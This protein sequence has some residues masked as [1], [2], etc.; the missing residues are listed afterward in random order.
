MSYE[1]PIREPLIRGN[2]SY[3]DI[4]EDICKHTEQLPGGLW[5]AALG[6]ALLALGFGTY[7]I[8]RTVFFGI[9]EWGIHKSVDWGWGITNFVW[10]VG[11][12][13]AGTLISAVL[14]LFR[15]RW[16][17]A[18][19]RS[20]EAMTIFAV[21]C[22]AQ[23]PGI[24]MGRPWMSFFVLPYPNSRGSLWPNFNSPL[25]WD[26]FAISTYLL[27]SL[28]FWYVGLIP[29]FASIRD[30]ATGVRQKIYGTLSMGW[31]GSARHWHRFEIL[32]LVL[33]GLATPLVFS[34]HTIVSFDFATSV[35]PGWHTT[36]FPPYFVAGA[37]FSGFAMVQTLL[38]IVREVMNLKD[39]ITITHIDVMNKIILVTGSVVGVAYI[40]ELVL[41]FYSGVE[42][43]AEQFWFRA[44][45]DMNWAYWIMMSCNVLSPQFFWFRKLRRSI[46]FTWILSIVVNVGMWYERFTI[47]VLSLAHDYLPSN[48]APYE[49]SWIEIGV[50]IGTLGIFFTLYLL[51]ARTFPVIAIA[52]VK[53]V[54]SVSGNRRREADVKA[55]EEG[56][57]EDHH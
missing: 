9:G 35:I 5:F 41:A 27:V 53:S 33:S 13:H 2:K 18:V 11:I 24:H 8:F 39:Y 55:M 48:W 17:T 47:I 6:I 7:C 4:T 25:L 51:Y 26:V 34:V 3:G 10:W 46:V 56:K 49:G 22:A 12:G 37:I 54:L 31:N 19:N 42:A 15:Q 28:M 16:R 30:R 36:I 29:D 40:T 50:F 44:A 20:A 32:C 52:E 23:F 1:S 14:F 43:E 38:L 45:G 57:E 21:I